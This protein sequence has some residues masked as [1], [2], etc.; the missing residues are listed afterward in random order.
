MATLRN[1]GAAVVAAASAV[2]AAPPTITVSVN[3]LKAQ[4]TVAHPFLAYNIDTG[5][6]YNNFNFSEPKLQ[7][8]IAQLGPTILR[9]GGTAGESQ[10]HNVGRY[11]NFS[12]RK[13]GLIGACAFQWNDY[14]DTL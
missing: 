7:N 14:P 10:K 2:Y 4:H 13:R 3:T 6:I 11:F 5:S 1:V 8:I 12:S 9:I